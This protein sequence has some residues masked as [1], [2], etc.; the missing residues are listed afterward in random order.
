MK[1]L[2][3]IRWHS[4]DIH[5]KTSVITAGRSFLLVSM[6]SAL[7]TCRF[8]ILCFGSAFACECLLLTFLAGYIFQSS[9]LCEMS[10]LCWNK[11][12]PIL[13]TTRVA[14]QY[15]QKGFSQQ[16]VC[17]PSCEDKNEIRQK[18]YRHVPALNIV[19][20]INNTNV[21]FWAWELLPSSL[22]DAVFQDLVKVP[23]RGRESSRCKHFL[24]CLCLRLN[25]S[26]MVN[27]VLQ[28]FWTL[29]P[30]DTEKRKPLLCSM[31][32]HF[33][34]LVDVLFKLCEKSFLVKLEVENK[35]EQDQP[36]QPSLVGSLSWVWQS[37]G[38]NSFWAG[39]LAV[40]GSGLL[41]ESILKMVE[42]RW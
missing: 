20:W 35:S 23:G 31:S 1:E 30:M 28:E 10:C 40:T 26:D 39:K 29:V 24:L 11:T 14:C 8:A 36:E 12:N 32:W 33:Q 34:I 41:G 15:F 5:G 17:Q 2:H 27:F 13:M 6:K 19:W 42:S 4:V 21:P 3:E 37:K 7:L 38:H 25:G 22:W 18:L 16:N 9:I